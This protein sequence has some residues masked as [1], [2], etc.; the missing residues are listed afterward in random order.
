MGRDGMEWDGMGWIQRRESEPL[1]VE[2]EE[3]LCEHECV[4]TRALSSKSC[5]GVR[6]ANIESSG[7][8]YENSLPRDVAKSRRVLRALKL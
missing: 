7:Y 1:Q 4:C 3:Y 5:V 6:E 8:Q 2:D